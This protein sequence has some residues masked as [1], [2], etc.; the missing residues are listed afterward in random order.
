[1]ELCQNIFTPEI[2]HS[3]EAA[4]R[5]NIPTIDETEIL[6]LLGILIMMGANDGTK[7]DYHDLWSKQFG[8]PSYTVTSRNKF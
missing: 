2:L 6:A 7:L 3:N 1:M 5:Q 4:M 8:R